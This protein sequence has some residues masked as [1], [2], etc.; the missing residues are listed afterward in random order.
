MGDSQNTA[1]MRSQQA[2]VAAYTSWAATPDRSARTAPARLAAHARFE[3]LVDPD[4]VMT[5]E[6][7]SKAADAAYRAHMRKCALKSAKVRAE[8]RAAASR[9]AAGA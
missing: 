3:A 6:A 7:R 1:S 5:P 2:R 4:S 9:S 8:R